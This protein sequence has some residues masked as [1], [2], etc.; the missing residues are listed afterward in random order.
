MHSYIGVMPEHVY[1]KENFATT[2]RVVGNEQP[3]IDAVRFRAIPNNAVAWRALQRGDVDV[4]RVDNDTWFRVTSDPAV[5]RR[6]V[7]HSVWPLGYNCIVWNLSD[8]LLADIRRYQLS[9]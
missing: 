1:R 5:Q 2:I 8:P 9:L 4:T 7:F 6:F 3:A